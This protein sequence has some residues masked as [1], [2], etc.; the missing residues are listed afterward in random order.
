MDAPNSQQ[1]GKVL[2]MTGIFLPWR[3]SN[4]ACALSNGLDD[5]I[6]KLPLELNEL[7]RGLTA[8]VLFDEGNQI[9]H[10]K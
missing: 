7:P 1:P 9:R 2:E 5:F 4:S 3:L 6:E 10:P 8:N